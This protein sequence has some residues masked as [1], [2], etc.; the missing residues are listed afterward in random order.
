MNVPSF[1]KV[2]MFISFLNTKCSPLELRAFTIFWSTC[3]QDFHLYCKTFCK[4]F[5]LTSFEFWREII[6]WDLSQNHF[7]SLLAGNIDQEVLNFQ[8]PLAKIFLRISSKVQSIS[9]LCHC[10][11]TILAFWFIICT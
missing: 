8:F 3:K 1:L 6:Y 2:N 4:C 5:F 9:T 10:D 11:L 7:F